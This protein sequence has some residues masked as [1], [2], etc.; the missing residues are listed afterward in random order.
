MKTT[1]RFTQ[2]CAGCGEWIAEDDDLYGLNEHGDRAAAGEAITDWVCAGCGEDL[3]EPAKPDPPKSVT[4]S[5]E[6]EK[7]H[8][9][10][11]PEALR[12]W[13]GES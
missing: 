5:H 13:W 2:K 8:R 6:D 7:K 3:P 4:P 1:A 11:T 9:T 12:P 10:G